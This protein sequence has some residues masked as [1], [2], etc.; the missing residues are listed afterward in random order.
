MCVCVCVCAYVGVCN[1]IKD[2]MHG[3]TINILCIFNIPL[4]TREMSLL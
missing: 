3:A 4:I 2:R 1:K